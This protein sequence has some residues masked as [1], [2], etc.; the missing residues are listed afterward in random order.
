MGL[1]AFLWPQTEPISSRRDFSTETYYCTECGGRLKI[2]SVKD[3]PSCPGCA[4][5][6]WEASEHTR[7]AAQTAPSSA[8]RST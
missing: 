5:R 3:L 7:Q 1:L 6:T 8:T 2:E 4:N